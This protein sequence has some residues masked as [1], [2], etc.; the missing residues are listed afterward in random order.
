MQLKKIVHLEK[1]EQLSSHLYSLPSPQ[2][3]WR[4]PLTTWFNISEAWKLTTQLP[5]LTREYLTLSA[6]L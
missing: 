5:S 2:A 1:V 3:V 6:E 4:A